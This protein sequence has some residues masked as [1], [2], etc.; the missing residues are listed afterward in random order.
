MLKLT[1]IFHKITRPQNILSSRPLPIHFEKPSYRSC[2]PS[3]HSTPVGVASLMS[4]S[5]SANMSTKTP[6][7]TENAP[8][9]LPGVYNQGIVAG[10]FVFCSGAIAMNADGKLIDGDVQEH[11]VICL[12]RFS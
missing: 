6:V 3:F 7:V 8:M 5:R 1:K 11:T 10:G 2:S 4:A 9:A 12:L